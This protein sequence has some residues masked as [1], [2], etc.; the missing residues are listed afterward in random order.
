MAFST[1]LLWALPKMANRI[2]QYS[3]LAILPVPYRGR[4]GDAA[5]GLLA[6]SVQYR[7]E[8]V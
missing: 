4:H 6:A 5:S 2:P 7:V 1:G 8:L 3:Y